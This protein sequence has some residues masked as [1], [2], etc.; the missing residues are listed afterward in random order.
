MALIKLHCRLHML[1]L[2]IRNVTAENKI[3]RKRICEKCPMFDDN[4]TDLCDKPPT[5]KNTVSSLGF[6]SLNKFLNE[7]VGVLPVT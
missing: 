2:S 6:S 7:Q 4:P 5:A 3:L 1:Q